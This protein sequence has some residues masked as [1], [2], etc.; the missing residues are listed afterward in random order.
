MD[1]G[2]YSVGGLPKNTHLAELRSP[3]EVPSFSRIEI[4]D[5]G[6]DI[7]EGLEVKDAHGRRLG[8]LVLSA[9][10][11]EE[12]GRLRAHGVS[13]FTDEEIRHAGNQEHDA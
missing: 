10:G 13:L 3:D 12:S 7:L 5:R 2:W 8:V 1:E 4:A 6:K 9:R 11:E